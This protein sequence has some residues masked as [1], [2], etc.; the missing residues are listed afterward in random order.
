MAFEIPDHFNYSFTRNVELLLQENTPLLQMACETRSFQGDKAQVVKQFGEVQFSTKD[1]RY[2]DTQF[3]EIDH[4][5]RWLFP[6]SYKLALPIDSEDELR[7]LDSPQSMYVAAMQASW[8]RKVNEVIRD[9]ALGTAQ[10]GVT[11]GTS[12][13]FDTTNQRIASSSV[14]LTIAKVRTA[15]RKLAEAYVDMTE[16]RFLII[17]PKQ[18][19]DLLKTTE[20]TDE[21]YADVKALVDG[22]VNRLLGFTVIE[23]NNLSQAS[24]EDRVIAM[25]KS[26]VVLGQWNNLTMRIGERADKD[27]LTQ[28]HASG[29][30][31]ATRTQEGKVVEILCA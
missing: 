18:M 24:S 2:S 23:Y 11:G 14:G 12:T 31:A 16:P 25:T 13:A 26:A 19:D 30:L 28:V 3:D 8:A 9:A 29:T 17:K 27:Y 1:Q 21:N 5:Q 10:T 15:R 4:K 20:A 6:Q 7:M 22:R